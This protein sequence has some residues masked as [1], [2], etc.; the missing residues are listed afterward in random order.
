MS[1]IIEV[2]SYPKCGNTWMRHIL[3]K[4][5]DLNVHFDVPD[6]HQQHDKTKEMIKTVKLK[7]EY[8]FYKS[9][10]L[11]HKKMNPDRIL[12]IYRHPLDVFMSSLNYMY[13]TEK[14]DFFKDNIL[15]S[16]DEL[17]D[18]NLL[19]DYFDEFIEDM[20]VRFFYSLLGNY[21]NYK[22]YLERAMSLDK[23]VALRYEDLFKDPYSTMLN[24]FE[25]LIPG[26]RI[27][28]C[29][30]VF[31][32]VNERTKNSGKKFFWKSK[33][34]VY[35]EYLDCAQIESFYSKHKDFLFSLGY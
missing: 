27:D 8:G 13:I 1:V 11:N 3:A 26:E 19:D 7:K 32:S 9:H 35:K 10:N 21:S 31:D 6:I 29:P 22:L 12:L 24:L 16:V 34:D 17:L 15:R 14:I 28:F 2:A 23:V 20:G 30:D 4:L 18:L 25:K 33:T 5:F